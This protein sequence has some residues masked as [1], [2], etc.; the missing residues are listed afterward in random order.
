MAITCN[1][2]QISNYTLL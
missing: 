1:A 2:V